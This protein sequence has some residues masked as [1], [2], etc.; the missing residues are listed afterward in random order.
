MTDADA[1]QIN[2]LMLMLDH[3]ARA[4]KNDPPDL[5]IVEKLLSDALDLVIAIQAPDDP[6]ADKA[7]RPGLTRSEEETTDV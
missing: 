4:L 1:K 2:R 5:V 7:L 3:A 6:Y